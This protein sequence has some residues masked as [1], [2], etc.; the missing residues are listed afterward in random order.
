MIGGTAGISDDTQRQ[1]RM[2]ADEELAAWIAEHGI[3]AFCRRWMDLPI[4]ASQSSII[5]PY[6]EL[7]TQRKMTNSAKGLQ[8]SLL[9]M[10]AGVM[11]PLWK[12][13]PE[14]RVPTLVVVGEND[15]KYRSL[16]KQLVQELPY[17][18]LRVIPNA[19]HCAQ[20]E[21]PN[22]FTKYFQE[23]LLEL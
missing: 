5:S 1:N 13:L 10:G 17:A 2:E 18:C 12:R 11:E 8:D 20:L 7:L 3:A 22:G 21:N 15:M 16:G 9:G 19:G 14:I 4:I 23:F 6:R